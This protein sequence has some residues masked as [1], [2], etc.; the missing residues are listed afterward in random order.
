VRCYGVVSETDNKKTINIKNNYNQLIKTLF[1]LLDVLD[2]YSLRSD[3]IDAEG[4]QRYSL[5]INL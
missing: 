4:G 3:L 2:M 5:Q 1:S